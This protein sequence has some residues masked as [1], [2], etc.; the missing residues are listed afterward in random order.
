MN[1][2]KEEDV[3][4]LKNENSD[5]IKE[6]TSKFEEIS[7]ETK[8][9]KEELPKVKDKDKDTSK[10]TVREEENEVNREKQISNKTRPR[11]NKV[12][13]NRFIMH[14]LSS[15]IKQDEQKRN[16]KK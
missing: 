5:L 12:V 2:S 8:N 4:K 16:K 9:I 15:Q 14:H 6:L 11:L 10:N 7:L 13:A 3:I 1:T